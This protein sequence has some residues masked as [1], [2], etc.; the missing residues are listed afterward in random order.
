MGMS[1][2]V[3]ATV[4][5]DPAACREIQ[6]VKSTMS[7]ASGNGD[8]FSY[9]SKWTGKKVDIDL[10]GNA[11]IDEP[12]E[13]TLEFPRDGNR[14][15]PDSRIEAGNAYRKPYTFK[16]HYGNKVIWFDHPSNET[17]RFIALREILA[18]V[19]NTIES[20]K[21]VIDFV[22]MLR[23]TDNKYCYI[24]S[25]VRYASSINQDVLSEG[26]AYDPPQVGADSVPGIP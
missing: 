15:Q 20:Y 13:V 5:G 16:S 12:N 1:F 22:H 4:E 25:T 23:G 21:T 8:K 9:P 26:M 11:D 10:D 24:K 3:V 7:G 18:G 19:E 6:L 14:Y 17:T 2:E